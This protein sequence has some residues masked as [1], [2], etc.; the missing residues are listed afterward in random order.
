MRKQAGE[1]HAVERSVVDGV[2]VVRLLGPS[3]VSVSVAPSI[4]NNAF[5][6]VVN[7][8]NAF[9]FPYSSLGEFAGRPELC[10]NPFLHPWANRLDEH[11]FYAGGIRYQLNRGLQNYLEDQD[12]QPIHGLLVF[13]SHWE[14]ERIHARPGAAEVTSRLDF[15]RHPEWM[16][17]FPFAHAIRMTYRLA[18]NEL[19]VRTVVENRGAET[20]PLS[21]G[22][23]PYFQLHDSRRDSW[24][25][26]LAARTVWDLNDRFTPDGTKS[27]IKEVLPVDGELGLRGQ[28]LDHVF[29][30]LNRDDD[31]WARFY[32]RGESERLTVAYG[33][34]YPVAV[35]YAPD[36]DGQEFICFEPMSGIT[37]AFNMAHRGRYRALPVV[38]PATSWSAAYRITVEGF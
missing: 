20:M 11:A 38:A 24:R 31:G 25:V 13:A 2:D 18:G 26:G 1:S 36:G 5:E 10:G 21:I 19:E 23:H 9:W 7:G 29:G 14:V 27:A 28:F 33:P 30:D 22:F 37:N 17:Q 8:K 3:G 16:A 12:G 32:V 4:G 35:V 34:D 15:S 6:F